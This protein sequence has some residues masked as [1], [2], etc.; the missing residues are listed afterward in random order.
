MQVQKVQGWQD[1]PGIERSFAFSKLRANRLRDYYDRERC[2]A[3]IKRSTVR[4]I[5][6]RA[7]LAVSESAPPDNRIR[8]L[9]SVA[10]PQGTRIEVRSGW[11]TYTTSTL[12]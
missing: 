10:R 4:V 1:P 7:S 5:E 11:A 3:K 8:Q 12:C 9:A 6:P 2:L